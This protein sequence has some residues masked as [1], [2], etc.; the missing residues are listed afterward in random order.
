M[1]ED[2]VVYAADGKVGLVTLN[3]PDK[4]NALTMDMRLAIE[5]VLKEAD[6]DPSTSVIV[7]RA[8]GRSFCVGFDVGGGHGPQPWRHDALKYQRLATSFRLTVDLA[9]AGDRLGAG[10]AL[11]GGCGSR[12]SAT[13]PAR[14][15][16]AVRR[17]RVLFSQVGRPCSCRSSSGTSGRAS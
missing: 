4:L 11:G 2:T 13:S 5:R 16:C 7:L 8:A 14:P 1:S 12:C 3:R 15:G 17:A 9:Q 6:A 10:H